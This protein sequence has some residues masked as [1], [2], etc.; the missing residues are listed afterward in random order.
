MSKHAVLDAV[1]EPAPAPRRKLFAEKNLPHFAMGI[2]FLTWLY[3]QITLG[4]AA[5]PPAIN[6]SF[7]AIS[8]LWFSFVI[9]EQSKGDTK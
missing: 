6:T 1:E 4:T 2:L 3:F 5:V 8:G 9:R 7:A